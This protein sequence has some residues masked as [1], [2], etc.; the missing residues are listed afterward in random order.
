MTIRVLLAKTPRFL[1]KNSGIDL[2]E[3]KGRKIRT[4]IKLNNTWATA[5]LIAV[6]LLSNP[7]RRAVMVV[8]I[9]A[10]IIN[11]KTDER[12]TFRVATRGTI[13]EVVME[14]DCTAPVSNNPQEKD[15][16]GLLKT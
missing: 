14:E 8:P 10:P 13:K 4:P 11:G 5:R 12:D 6:S 15:F 7:A 9:L 3:E 1:A 2:R 16:K